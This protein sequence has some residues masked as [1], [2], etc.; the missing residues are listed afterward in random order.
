MSTVKLSEPF[1]AIIDTGAP[2]SLYRN[3]IAYIEEFDL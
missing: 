1:K 2:T 3:K